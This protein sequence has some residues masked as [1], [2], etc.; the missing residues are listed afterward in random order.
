MTNNSEGLSPNFRPQ[1]GVAFG[2]VL[3]GAFGFGNGWKGDGVNN[4]F[5]IPR[6]VGNLLSSEGTLEFWAIY[7]GTNTCV[8]VSGGTSFMIFFSANGNFYC[9]INNVDIFYCPTDFD[10]KAHYLITWK[11]GLAAL[12]KNGVRLTTANYTA[13]A[14]AFVNYNIGYPD[15]AGSVPPAFPMDEIRLYTVELNEDQIRASYNNGFGNNPPVTEYLKYWFQF[16]KFETLD[17]S[18]AQ[19]N[20]NLLLGIRDMSGKN[21]HAQQFNMDTNPASPTFVLKPF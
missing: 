16:E 6:M 10:V 17:F 14:A 13:P 19:D 9:K 7:K 18:A 3:P 1:T 12:Y 11:A 4:Y 2:R 21:N 5:T 15:Q 20:S 8:V